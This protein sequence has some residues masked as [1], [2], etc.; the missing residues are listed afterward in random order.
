MENSEYY[1]RSGL[2]FSLLY[3]RFLYIG[4]WV[5]MGTPPVCT[6]TPWL[7]PGYGGWNDGDG[8]DDDDTRARGLT[9]VSACEW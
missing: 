2:Y 9:S 5:H 7:F 6:V 3:I 1:T 4:A 8:D